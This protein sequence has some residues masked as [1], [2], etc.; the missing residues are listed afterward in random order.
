MI[1]T[2][3]LPFIVRGTCTELQFCLAYFATTGVTASQLMPTFWEAVC[4][5]ETSCNLWVIAAT[6]DGATPN[7]RFFRLHKPLDGNA[8]GDVCYRTINLYA[9]HRYIYFFADPPHL[10][11]TTRNCLRS[12]GSGTCTRYMRNNGHILH[13]CSIKMLT[14]P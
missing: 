13:Q 3:A 8:E 9:P 10:I 1:A 11:K 4:I 12:S 7:K 5:L 2:H 14:M 6:A